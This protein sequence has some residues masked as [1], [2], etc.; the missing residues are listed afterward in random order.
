MTVETGCVV[1]SMDH[2]ME[3][4][5]P[6]MLHDVH[7]GLASRSRTMGFDNRLGDHDF[8]EDA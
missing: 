5:D 7:A 3:L 2:G 8:E 6:N 4:K 1:A